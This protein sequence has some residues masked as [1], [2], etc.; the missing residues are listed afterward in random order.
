[1]AAAAPR[2]NASAWS[3]G[4]AEPCQ[5]ESQRKRVSLFSLTA[6]CG[7][8]HVAQSAACRPPRGRL[9][10]GGG[11]LCAGRVSRRNWAPCRRQ[12][13]RAPPHSLWTRAHGHYLYIFRARSVFRSR[14]PLRSASRRWFL[15]ENR[16]PMTKVN[17]VRLQSTCDCDLS[18]YSIINKILTVECECLIEL[19]DY[20]FNIILIDYK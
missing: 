6:C 2:N 9:C 15:H 13:E 19:Y 18:L 16:P 20:L 12:Q 17:V 10:G 8:E 14:R 4:N 5:L 7:R 11:Q 1:M 3:S